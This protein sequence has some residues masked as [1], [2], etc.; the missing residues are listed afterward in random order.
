MKLQLVRQK[1]TPTLLE[2]DF[3]N[4]LIQTVNSIQNS[5]GSGQVVVNVDGDG[6]MTIGLRGGTKD[7]LIC[8][9]GEPVEITIL[10]AG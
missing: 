9:N 2:A 7:V 4:K 5:R 8:E 3:A 6:R 1:Q 10:T